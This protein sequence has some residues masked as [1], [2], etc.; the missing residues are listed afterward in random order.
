MNTK[1][2]NLE[3]E[4]LETLS[5]QKFPK[6]FITKLGSKDEEF[7][8]FKFK[9]DINFMN[10]STILYK[11][12]RNLHKMNYQKYKE[13]EKLRNAPNSYYMV[14]NAEIRDLALQFLPIKTLPKSLFNINTLRRLKLYALPL[15]SFN[16]NVLNLHNLLNLELDKCNITDTML[17]NI[18][19]PTSVQHISISNNQ[20][21]QFP[22]CLS[23]L[24]LERLDLYMNSIRKI[25]VDV[26][27]YGL[28]AV[29]T[30]SLLSNPLKEIPE[31]F[32]ELIQLENIAFN[33]TQV[34]SISPSI[35]NLCN[36]KIILL[37]GTKISHLPEELFSI[38]KLEI[39]DIS[40]TKVKELTNNVIDLPN[41]KEIDISQTK[42][43]HLPDDLFYLPNVKRI[44]IS[45]SV[46]LTDSQQELIKERQITVKL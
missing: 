19:I 35:E 45:G 28:S 10:Y 44:Y 17:E 21:T 20:I 22:N 23:M 4:L 5:K 13:V 24:N 40:N 33:N 30:I 39:L 27:N 34:V 31:P 32:Y 15:T 9:N 12:N 41:L 26:Q 29:K 43:N 16:P 8:I 42:I 1:I 14:Q 36:L 18:E 38:P 46:K 3:H 37:N 7:D 2:I 11:V 25:P 6:G